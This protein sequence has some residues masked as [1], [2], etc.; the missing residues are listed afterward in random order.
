[1]TLI[2]YSVPVFWLGLV[3]LLVFYARL[4]WVG[5]PGRIDV[6][7]Q[8]V[9]PPTTGLMLVDTLVAGD[10]GA[11]ASALRHLVLPASILGYFS[12]AYIGRMTRSLML[13]QLG[14]EYV[15]AAEVKGLRARRV[16]WGHAFA[17]VRVPLLTVVVLSYGYL[18]EGAVLTETVFA[19]PGLG[20]YITQALFSADIN[21]VLG[22]TMVVGACFVSL[23]LL[24]DL[25]YGVLDVRT[26]LR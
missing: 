11:F 24:S 18:L 10:G 4:G 16:V 5:G 21:A 14:Q 3:G 2:G 8:Y 26:R 7:Y 23:N 13:E 19:W 6:A 17:N 12:M 25:L 15:L 20:R 22:G 1:M 9:I